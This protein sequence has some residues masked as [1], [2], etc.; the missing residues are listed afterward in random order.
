MIPGV[1]T[2]DQRHA[3]MAQAL[4]RFPMLHKKTGFLNKR[5]NIAC[6]GPSLSQTWNTICGPVISVSGAHDLLVEKGVVPDYHVECDPRPHKVEMLNNPQRG[7]TYL[8]AS[9][10]HPNF[11]PKLN[12]FAV[13]LWHLVN[14]DDLETLKWV[15]ANHPGGMQ[16]LIGGG[17]TV[18]Q[19]AMNVGAALGFRKFDVYG[20]DLS[21]ATERHAGK[22]TGKPESEL[23]CKVDKRTFR[24]TKQM[25]QA[26]VEME[27][28]L[29]EMDVD[30]RFHGDGMMQ[31]VA[32]VIKARRK[33]A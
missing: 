26:C 18:G 6:Y 19:R 16:S 33:A 32:K 15:A 1:L 9:V 20:M 31:E 14:G 22:H 29:Q 28:F 10:C 7:T 24:T 27:R 13:R 30:V 25:A 11:W 17:S 4:G 3:Q 12:G 23:L 8:I 2:N 21:F 5:I